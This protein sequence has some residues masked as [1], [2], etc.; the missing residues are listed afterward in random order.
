MCI[1][2]RQYTT[3]Y[4]AIVTKYCVGWFASG[5]GAAGL[6]GALAWWIVRP[7]GVRLGLGILSLL[8]FGMAVAFFSL[9]KAAT[10]DAMSDTR[11]EAAQALMQS[12][13][14]EGE[15]EELD[16]STAP[17]SLSFS[18]KMELLRPMLLPYILPLVSV[19]FAEYTIN[20][21][22]VRL[23]CSHAGPHAFVHGTRVSKA[24]AFVVADPYTARLL[25]T[26]PA[27]LPGM[28]AL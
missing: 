21:G 10:Q 12:E 27:H 13:N 3:R 23:M 28:Q 5:T 8:P 20:Q 1:R 25:P 11:D 17:T 4:P 7:L 16:P 2:D 22:V 15:G 6:A 26:I 24:L 19:Y 9:P 14:Q 18:H